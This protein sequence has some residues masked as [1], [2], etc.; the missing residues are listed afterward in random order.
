MIPP[1][2]CEIARFT[3]DIPAMARFYQQLLGV[4][5]Q[6]QAEGIAIFVSGGVKIL[7]HANYTPGED[8]LPP[9]DHVAFAVPDVDR[10]CARLV[11]NGLHLVSEPRD[12]PW[13]RSAHLRDPDGHLIELSQ[14]Q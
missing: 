4:E 9:E 13:G 12:W 1:R 5:P 8:D 10:T 3:E 7:I 11:E 14:G 2:V 6:Y